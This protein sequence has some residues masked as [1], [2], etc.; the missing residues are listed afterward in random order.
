MESYR[1]AG[2]AGCKFKVGGL[3]PEEDFKRVD[4]ARRAV[5]PDFKLVVDANRGWSAR[6]AIRFARLVEPLDIGWVGGP[7]P[8]DDDVG[9]MAPERQAT[10]LPVSARPADNTSRSVRP[11]GGARR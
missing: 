3:A 9:L 10:R 1:N 2:M 5:G 11:V 4:A 7:C 8:W 6:D